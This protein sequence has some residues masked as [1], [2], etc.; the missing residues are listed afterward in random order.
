MFVK[1]Y[2]SLIEKQ[3]NGTSSLS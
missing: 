1:L 3:N 2:D